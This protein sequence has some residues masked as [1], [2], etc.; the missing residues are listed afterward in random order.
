MRRHRSVKVMRN[1]RNTGFQIFPCAELELQECQ[2]VRP[3]RTAVHRRETL[4]TQ[5][6]GFVEKLRGPAT[7]PVE[8]AQTVLNI[9]LRG[10]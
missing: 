1:Q 4:S 5:R 2:P 6:T 10:A 8:D 7:R 9:Y 3:R